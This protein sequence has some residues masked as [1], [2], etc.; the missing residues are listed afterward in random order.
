MCIK[1]HKNMLK[2]ISGLTTLVGYLSK[3]LKIKFILGK[4]NVCPEINTQ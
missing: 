4:H 2:I 3:R 1:K